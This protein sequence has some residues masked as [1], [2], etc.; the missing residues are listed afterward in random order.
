MNGSREWLR[1]VGGAVAVVALVAAAAVLVALAADVL[2]WDRTMR[3]DDIA[4]DRMPRPHG[5]R[6]PCFPRA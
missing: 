4:Y 1:P 2:R 6:T 5:S 3:D